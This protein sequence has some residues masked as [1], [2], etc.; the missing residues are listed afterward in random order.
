MAKFDGGYLSLA[1]TPLR[2]TSTGSPLGLVVGCESIEL[3]IEGIEHVSELLPRPDKHRRVVVPDSE[4]K[5][6]HRLD[7]QVVRPVEDQRHL[8]DRIVHGPLCLTVLPPR[9]T[10]CSS[11]VGRVCVCNRS[12]RC[13]GGLRRRGRFRGRSRGRGFD[14]CHD[15]S[16]C[17]SITF[18]S[19]SASIKI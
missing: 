10:A 5:N 11:E 17:R 16:F 19:A 1:R 6:L 14:S 3:C 9:R 2:I 18:I 4:D 15:S 8:F 7:N 12:L 13:Y